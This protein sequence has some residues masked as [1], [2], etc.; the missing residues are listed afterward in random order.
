MFG[1]LLDFLIGLA[2]GN[3]IG[4]TAKT[5]RNTAQIAEALRS[6]APA[7]QPVQPRSTAQVALIV[8]I[9]IGLLLIIASGK[10]H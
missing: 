7:P 2:A 1:V 9:L 6:S 10:G 8:L 5:A 4:N 3:L